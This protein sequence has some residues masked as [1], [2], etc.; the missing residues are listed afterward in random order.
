MRDEEAVDLDVVSTD[1]DGTGE[2][3][4]AQP[5]TLP[6]AASL[7]KFVEYPRSDAFERVPTVRLE[8]EPADELAPSSGDLYRFALCVFLALAVAVAA[9]M[10]GRTE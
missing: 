3:L 10:F 5:V 9:V 1:P 6:E 7:P 2:W 8:S 4:H